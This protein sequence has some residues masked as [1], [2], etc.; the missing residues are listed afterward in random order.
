MTDHAERVRR[1]YEAFA[2]G[3]LKGAFEPMGEDIVWH[4]AE[5]LPHAGVYEGLGAVRRAVF[6]VMPEWWE[7]FSAEPEEV[8]GLGDHVVALGR[9][10]GRAKATGAALDAPFA[11]VWTF[12]EGRAVLFRQY[13]D[14]SAWLRALG[15][16]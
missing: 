9:Y 12:R 16:A 13:T 7:T 15:L 3:D 4:E 6:D 11:H 1:S 5:G 2:Q 10:R 8:L 14:T